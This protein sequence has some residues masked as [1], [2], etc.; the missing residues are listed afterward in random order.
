MNI[1]SQELGLLSYSVI[2]AA[3]SGDSEAIIKAIDHY[4]K[5][6]AYLSMHKTCSDKRGFHWE[7]NDELCERL[8]SKLIYA[9]LDFKI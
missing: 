2:I 9:V 5:Y 8:K 7:I 3:T 4:S 1:S 6:I